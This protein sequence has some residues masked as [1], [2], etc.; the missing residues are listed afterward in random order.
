MA[1][2][3]SVCHKGQERWNPQCNGSQPC[4]L[5]CSNKDDWQTMTHTPGIPVS[6]SSI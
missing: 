6:K 2:P 4:S 5:N 1:P 3:G